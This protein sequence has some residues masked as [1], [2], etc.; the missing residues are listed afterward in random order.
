MTT[1]KVYGDSR[2]K[3][4]ASY[5]SE[6]NTTTAHIEIIG[7]GGATI[8][9]LASEVWAH[10]VKRPYDIILFNGGVNEFT[11]FDEDTGLYKLIFTTAEEATDFCVAAFQHFELSFHQRFP[12]SQLIYAQ[13]SGFDLS[14][15]QLTQDHNPNHQRVIDAAIQNIN[16]ELVN[17]NSRN[18]VPTCWMGKHVHR[19][20]QNGETTN[21]YRQLWDG[22][23]PS[24][25]LLELWARDIVHTAYLIS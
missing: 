2:L 19:I 11:R 8:R 4:L 6:A 16:K 13:L 7:R 25:N 23:H 17:I 21:Y 18:W 24:S 1:I 14:R 22:L 3:H 20:R 15:Y 9:S 12:R 5:V 10:T